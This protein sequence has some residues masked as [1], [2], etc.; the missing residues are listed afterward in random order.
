MQGAGPALVNRRRRRLDW[1]RRK[2][3][4]L[5]LALGLAATLAGCG[6]NPLNTA[7]TGVG[8]SVTVLIP[9]SGNTLLGSVRVRVGGTSH[10]FARNVNT[11]A[12]ACGRQATLSA[13]SADPSV[14]PFTEWTL[15]GSTSSAA[16]LTVTVDGV[17]SIRPGFRV[18]KVAPVPP[19]PPSPSAKVT[20]T[21][22]ATP[23]AVTLDQW[24]SYDSATQSV[25]WKLVAAYQDV[26]HGLSFDGEAHGAMKVTVPAGWSVTV[27]FSNGGTTN[28]SAVVVTPTGL[29]AVFPGAGT[30]SPMQGTAPGQTASFTFTPSQAGSYRMACLMPGHEAAGMWE[31]FIVASG[32]LPGVQ[33]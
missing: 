33:I 22:S 14:H 2:T 10:D 25:I 9:S 18:P 12:V 4:G 19:P 5:G 6:G 20:P 11:V 30:P 1:T 32:G 31:T 8:C 17:L 27:D 7:D 3:V 24:V 21:P 28:H 26:N 13:T 15:P 23:S 16:R 29:E